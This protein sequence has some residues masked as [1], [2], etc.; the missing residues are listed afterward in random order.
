MNTDKFNLVI[1][2]FDHRAVKIIQPNGHFYSAKLYFDTEWKIRHG[3][4]ILHLNVEHISEL[5]VNALQNL[6]IKMLKELV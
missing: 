4:D 3:G 2:L 6:E 1:R 5:A